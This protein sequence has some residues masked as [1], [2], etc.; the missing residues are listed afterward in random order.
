MKIWILQ[1]GEPLDIDNDDPRP[2]RAMNLSNYLVKNGHQVILWSSAFHHRDKVHRSKKYE[3]IKINN[4]YQIRLIPSPGYSKNISLKR[5]WDHLIMSINLKKILKNETD[6]P[7]IAFIGFPPIENAY[8]FSGWLDRKE[9]PYLV[10]IKDQWPDFFLQAINSKIRPLGKFFLFP[11]FQMTKK[12]FRNSSGLTAMSK[13]FLEWGI[14]FSNKKNNKNNLVVPL[15][16]PSIVLSEIK[17]NEATSW[18]KDKIKDIEECK[19]IIFIGSHYPSLDFNPIFEAAEILLEKNI[20]CNFIICGFG[21]Q[22]SKL[23]EKADKLNNVYFPG[24]VNQIQISALASMSIATISPFKNINNYT[25]NIPNKIVDSLALGLPILSPLKGEVK[26]MILNNKLGLV[27][28]E[29]SG[30]SL[31][32]C[33][34]KLLDDDF[35]VNKFSNNSKKLYN[36]KYSYDH[37]YGNLV[38]HIETMAKNV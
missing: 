20:D 32:I 16:A 13:S 36:E 29:G 11:L 30:E 12:I 26:N 1:T 17:K 14:N 6:L 5:F 7:D 24:W 31:S 35:I 3:S 27:Y 15:T 33:I 37:V 38:K 19:N 25:V 4:N 18:W 34:L 9:I 21:E 28:D 2:M 22:T 10:D 23:K 8:V